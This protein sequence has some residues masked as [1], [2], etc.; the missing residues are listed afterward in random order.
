M[1]WGVSKKMMIYLFGAVM[2]VIGYMVHGVLFYNKIKITN[3]VLSETTKLAKILEKE[4]VLL[5]VTKEQKGKDN[6]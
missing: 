1:Y 6:A 4:R 5:G 2:F 3:E